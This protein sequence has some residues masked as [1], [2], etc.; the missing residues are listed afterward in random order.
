MTRIA[1]ILIGFTPFHLLPMLELVSEAQGDVYLFHPDM[2]VD[3]A[4]GLRTRVSF[5]G[6]GDT[7]R[8]PRVLRYL[9][10]GS[11]IDRILREHDDVALYA[12][13]PFN[14]LANYALFHPRAGRRYIYQDGILNYYDARNPLASSK[15]IMRQKIKATLAGMPYTVYQGHLSGV[16]ALPIAGGYFTHPHMIARAA[17]F[18]LV[19]RLHLAAASLA[20]QTAH[21]GVLFLDQPIEQVVGSDK[22]ALLRARTFA[23]VERLGGT[24]IYKPHYTQKVVARPAEWQVLGD[25]LASLP[26]EEV[27]ARTEVSQV[28]SYFTSALAN[29]A[30]MYPGI[31]CH[32]TAAD[33]VPITVDGRPTSLAE[34]FEGFGVRVVRLDA[35]LGSGVD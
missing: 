29:I 16:D 19:K 7:P 6:G 22:A 23:Y 10:A 31:V 33:V 13:H 2:R 18:P 32:A 8:G 3:I 24:V 9:R 20:G 25:T 27:I 15:W 34:L 1:S 21:G 14:P 12:P 35:A 5:L 28:V 11:E 30:V 26:A 4:Q 17:R